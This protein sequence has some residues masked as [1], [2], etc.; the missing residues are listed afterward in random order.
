MLKKHPKDD[1]RGLVTVVNPVHKLMPSIPGLP[2]SRSLWLKR[3]RDRWLRYGCMVA[4]AVVCFLVWNYYGWPNRYVIPGLFGEGIDKVQTTTKRVAL[5]FDDGPDPRYTTKISQILADAGARAT[6]F[7]LGR[8]GQQ[9]PELVKQ[10]AQQGHELGNHTW[11]HRDL[12]FIRPQTI[13][14]ELESTD[15]LL[16]QWINP[17]SAP[18]RAPFGHSMWMLPQVLKQRQQANILWT[19]HLNDWEPISPET[20]MQILKPKFG[21]GAIILLHD[22]DGTSQGGDRHN[23]VA[24]V[25]QILKEYIP[26]EYE[27]VTV[28]ELLASG[29]PQHYW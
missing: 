14:D 27:F 13:R 24:V 2:Q 23:T 4:L 19:V 20:M 26:Q 10:L 15:Q 28:S 6:F 9:Y 7:I 17:L 1:D 25:Q 21:P 18:F 5:T 8:H 22:G 29:K 12:R 3:V 11:S 16:A